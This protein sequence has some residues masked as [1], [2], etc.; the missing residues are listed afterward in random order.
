M[1]GAECGWQTS[2]LLIDH[3]GFASKHDDIMTTDRINRMHRVSFNEKMELS[4]LDASISYKELNDGSD[5]LT[6]VGSPVS[7]KSMSVLVSGATASP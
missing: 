3:S 1:N 6:D 7:A 4:E 5:I 2:V